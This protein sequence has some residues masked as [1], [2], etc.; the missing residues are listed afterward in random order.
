[1]YSLE[2]ATERSE[3]RRQRH[4]ED[5][6]VA[7]LGQDLLPPH[8]AAGKVVVEPHRVLERL[9]VLRQGPHRRFAFARITDEYTRHE[10]PPM[11][12]RQRP[13]NGL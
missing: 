8:L 7:D 10:H 1:M 13:Q 12:V 4:H 5:L 9:D 2:Q 6:A 3:I 11:S